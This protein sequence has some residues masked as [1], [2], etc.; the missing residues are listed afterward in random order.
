MT[1]R[2]IGSATKEKC[3]VALDS[4]PENYR[5]PIAT[6]CGGTRKHISNL[7]ILGLYFTQQFCGLPAVWRSSSSHVP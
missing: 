4:I 2:M 5:R 6:A 3:H 7:K 1:R